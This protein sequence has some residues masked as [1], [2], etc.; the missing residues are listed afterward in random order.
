MF[1]GRIIVLTLLVFAFDLTGA[2]EVIGNGYLILQNGDKISFTSLELGDAT[3][4]FSSPT[5]GNSTA[6]ALSEIRSIHTQQANNGNGAVIGASVGLLAVFMHR[7]G[8]L[9]RKAGSED[10]GAKE[11][12]LIILGGLVGFLTIDRP[13]RVETVY[14]R[15]E[16][17]TDAVFGWDVESNAV[18]GR[19][20]FTW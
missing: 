10:A 5:H 17:K 19:L 9:G 1:V 3:V 2:S 6:L 8:T 20:S 15:S 12:G 7:S 14:P 11:M 13:G 16:G 4:K 18:V